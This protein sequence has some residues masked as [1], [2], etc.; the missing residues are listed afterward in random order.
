[1]AKYFLVRQLTD[2]DIK[3]RRSLSTVKVIADNVFDAKLDKWNQGDWDYN[4][5]EFV[6]TFT[7]LSKPNAPKLV[8]EDGVSYGEL[9]AFIEEAFQTQIVARNKGPTP[10]PAELA[11]AV[12][13]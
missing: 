8:C 9:R 11:Q 2:F 7:K 13:E 3:V 12:A 1:M 5:D 10:P 4:V 6:K